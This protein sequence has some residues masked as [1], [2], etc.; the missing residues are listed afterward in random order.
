MGADYAAAF[1]AEVA[2]DGEFA[3][4]L[5]DDASL[6]AHANML[7]RGVAAI[8]RRAASEGAALAVHEQIVIVLGRTDL[9]I[10]DRV[11]R[12]TRLMLVLWEHDQTARH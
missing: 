1:F 2:A 6:A 11:C 3:A 8:E 12:L 4:A 7:R 10:K 5:K 9:T